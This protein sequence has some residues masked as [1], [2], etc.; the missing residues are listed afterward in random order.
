M[1][2][3]LT[4]VYFYFVKFFLRFIEYFSPFYF[5]VVT[6]EKKFGSSNLDRFDNFP[7]VGKNYAILMQGPF[8]SNN[9]F[10]I[11]T[12]K[13]YRYLYPNIT[14]VFST[15][16]GGI[17]KIE[18]KLL[19]EQL[20]IS[21]LENKYPDNAGVSNVN[22]QIV[23]TLSGLQ[24]LKN[25]DVKYVLKSR[26][27]QR[28]Y[29]SIDFLTY[30]KLLQTIYPI[31]G[32]NIKK[33]LVI[34]SMNSFI[35]RLY[36]VS[37]MFMFGEIED[38]LIY[39]DVPLDVSISKDIKFVDPKYFM[40]NFL[41]EGYFLKYF[42]KKVSFNPLWTYSDSNKFLNDFF[43]VVDKEQ[44]DLFWFKYNRFFES[45]NF[46]NKIDFEYRKR[47]NFVNWILSQNLK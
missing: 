15:W 2:S 42:F 32:K 26:S 9:E 37:D 4:R 22:Y 7:D 38:M 29:N 33:R 6:R 27:D 16:E 5:S 14:I 24:F 8:I 40:K 17:D 46:L 28:I 39:W 43:V 36:G 19:L 18:D 47:Y 20:N 41:A 25:A 21:I 45:T 23:T 1:N 35:N 30:M 34:C 13:L 44:L 3:N 31:A 11:E 12:L 10:T